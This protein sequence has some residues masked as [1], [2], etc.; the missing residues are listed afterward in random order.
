MN[1]HPIPSPFDDM[2]VWR[3]EAG[4]YSY[5][6]LKDYVAYRASAKQLGAIPFDKTRITLD[7]P[8]Y[9][10]FDE[11]VAACKEFHRKQLA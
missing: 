6:I 7:P 4:K 9:K 3:A 5:V 2:W 11:A 8:A 1:F 10:T